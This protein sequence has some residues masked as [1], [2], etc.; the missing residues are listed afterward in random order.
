MSQES[1][2]AIQTGSYLLICIVPQLI[3]RKGLSL[4]LSLSPLYVQAT[5]TRW[6]SDDC[7]ENMR[8]MVL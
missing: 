3:R 5:P 4:S 1:V 2:V 6:K 8:K 7:C